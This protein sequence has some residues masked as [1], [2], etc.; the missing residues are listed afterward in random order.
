[1]SI[2]CQV[3]ME[4]MD[5]LA[6]R[7]LAAQWDNVGL[8]A[9]SPAQDVHKI[10]VTL[11]VTLA[12][13]EQAIASGADLIIAHHPLLLKP[14]QSL[15]TDSPQGKL[16]AAILRS[17]IAVF[18]A[19]TNL[20]IADGGVNDVLAAKLQLTDVRSLAVDMTDELLKLVVFVP[21]THAQAV[22]DALAKA[23]AGHIG[24]YSH[25]MFQAEGKGT[26][27]PLAGAEPF[28]GRQGQLEQVAE[29]R[30]ETILPAK[31]RRRVV[32]ALLKVHPYEEVAYDLY[33]LKNPGATY[34]LGRIGRLTAPV[35]LND[36]A[37][38][39]KDSLQVAFVRITGKSAKTIT[40]VAVCG[41]SGAGLLHKAVFA[42]ADVLITGDVKYHE[43]QEAVTAGIALIDA[44]HF[45]TE[46]P[47][48]SAVAT[49]LADCAIAGKWSVTIDKDTVNTDVFQVC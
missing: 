4:A 17:G 3:V 38:M 14:I 2:K 46:Q 8:L 26:F 12:V 37:A 16:I 21:Q 28:I 48:V 40:T 43:A 13:V 22:H 10:M 20:D 19:H 15:R 30:L 1:M 11:D 39:V 9:G 18:A 49:Y 44:G 45:A 47:I 31:I 29:I 33:S 41:G 25:C 24:H 35:A 6:P 23:G 42:G 32:S 27:M 7:Q 36:L 5:R 34:G